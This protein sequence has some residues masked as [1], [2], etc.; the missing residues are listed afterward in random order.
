MSVVHVIS[1]PVLPNIISDSIN[2][3]VTGR[4]NKYILYFYSSPIFFPHRWKLCRKCVEEEEGSKKISAEEEREPEEQV[5]E[6]E[7]SEGGGG[8]EEESAEEEG[9][10]IQLVRVL[11]VLP[12]LEKKKRKRTDGSIADYFKRKRGRPRRFYKPNAKKVRRGKKRREGEAA[13]VLRVRRVEGGWEM[14]KHLEDAVEVLVDK[15]VEERKVEERKVEERKAAP[16]RPKGYRDWSS[17][18]WWPV[19]KERMEWER[20]AKGQRSVLSGEI[21]EVPRSTVYS[22]MGRLG[23]S[24]VTREN[25]FP[26]KAALLTE[27]QVEFLQDVIRARD[28]ANNGMA[29]KEV[30]LLIVDLGGAASVSQAENHFDYLI[31]TKRLRWLKK[32]GRVVTAQL[33]TSERSHVTIGQQYRWHMMIEGE[34]EELRRTNVPRVLFQRLAP[35]FQLNLDETCFLCNDGILRIVGDKERR[36]HDKN[37]ADGR[38]SITVLRVGSAAG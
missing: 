18:R 19:L 4:T 35:Y 34:W 33:T 31:R 3:F 14:L 5:R 15:E 16:K 21:K 26:R 30:I 22:C 17:D 36:H 13:R 6:E 2:I 11:S 28:I 23:D 12:G 24:E 1:V 7:E 32:G 25:C 8:E 38:F 27:E 9:G 37:V 29:R 20:R 10:E